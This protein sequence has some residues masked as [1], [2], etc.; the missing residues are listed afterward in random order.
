M[1]GLFMGVVVGVVML[2]IGVDTETSALVDI[3]LIL[4][5][6]SLFGAGFLQKEENASVRL[7]MLVAGGIILGFS[8]TL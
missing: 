5:T 6:L 2:V 1:S 3:G 8:A 7:G 4:T